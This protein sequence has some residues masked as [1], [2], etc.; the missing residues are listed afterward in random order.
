MKARFWRWTLLFGTIGLLIPV[1]LLF[2]YW[3]FGV[4]FGELEGKLWPSSLMF[5]ALDA[6]DTRT[7]TIVVVYAMAL[8][9]NVIRYAVLGI[10]TWPLAYIFFRVRDPR[11]SLPRPR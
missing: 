11:A 8:L 6:P 10:L 4:M 2:R 3:A 9:G 1:V 5:T 7:S